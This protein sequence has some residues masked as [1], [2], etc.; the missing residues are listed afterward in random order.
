MIDEIIVNVLSS[1]ISAAALRAGAAA[2]SVL[3]AKSDGQELVYARWFEAYQPAL[4]LPDMSVLS[5]DDKDDLGRALRGYEVQGVLHELL[6]ARLTGAPQADIARIRSLWDSTMRTAGPIGTPATEELFDY[7]DAEIST[8]VSRMKS[9][10]PELLREI[11]SDAFNARI[12]SILNAIERHAAS[13]SAAPARQTDEDFLIRYKEHVRNH[14]GKLEPP[15]FQRRRR[16]LFE[17]L[18]V[19]PTIY[20]VA[21][22]DPRDPPV[23]ISL[24]M[25]ADQIDRTVLLGDPGG[26]KTTA[27]NALLTFHAGG[28]GRRV[29]FLVTLREF[30]AQ[31]LSV[32]GYIEH[33]LRVFYQCAARG[34]RRAVAA[35][36]RCAGHL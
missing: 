24:S 35:D 9:Q 2:R 27:A 4:V 12:V 34:A 17:D 10:V 6:A 15:D 1:V 5:S 23:E 3:R 21:D 18:Y 20:Q 7:Y 11:R 29:P 26:G 13:L 14:H 19:A 30:A 32:V 22:A 31:D 28:A 25:L 36:W 16:V 33:Q 8:L